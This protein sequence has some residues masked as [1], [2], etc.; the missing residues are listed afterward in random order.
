MICVYS[1]GHETTEA[2][3]QKLVEQMAQKIGEQSSQIR[4][5]EAENSVLKQTCEH[6]L[7]DLQLYR[8]NYRQMRD[9]VVRLRAHD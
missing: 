9:E 2:M 3:L 6:A 7:Q 4:K 8:K 1:P 5:L